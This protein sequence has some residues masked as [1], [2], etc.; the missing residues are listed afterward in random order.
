MKDNGG[1]EIWAVAQFFT[2]IQ[3]DIEYLMQSMQC[4]CVLHFMSNCLIDPIDYYR[5]L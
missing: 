3:C 4:I 5:F 1:M 2:S